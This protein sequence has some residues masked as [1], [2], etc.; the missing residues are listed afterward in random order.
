MTNLS[1]LVGIRKFNYVNRKWIII[2]SY[3]AE[4]Y[5]SNERK[6]NRMFE[7]Q[8]QNILSSILLSFM[9]QSLNSYFLQ[10]DNR[11]IM[12]SVTREF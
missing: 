10:R 2:T 9:K 6:Y 4:S 8:K 1:K 3:I 12:L 5:T 11:Y 7:G